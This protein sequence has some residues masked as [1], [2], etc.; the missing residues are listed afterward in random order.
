MRKQK[1]FLP[2]AI[3]YKTFCCW[4]LPEIVSPAG[5]ELL[6]FIVG[7]RCWNRPKLW[8]PFGKI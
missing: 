7:R 2:K 3:K 5:A 1:N 6:R 8:L 4:E